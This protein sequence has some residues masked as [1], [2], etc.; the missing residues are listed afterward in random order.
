MKQTLPTL[1]LGFLFSIFTTNSY[2]QSPNGSAS[3]ALTLQCAS[4]T[5]NR[6]GIAYNPN[7]QYYYSINAGSGSYPIETFSSTGTPLASIS[8]GY[9]YRGFWWNPN[10]ST[11]E[12]KAYANGGIVRQNVDASFFPLGTGTTIV[13]GSAPDAQSCGDYDWVDDE[14]LYYYNG[15]AYRYDRST[16]TVISSV[17]I[18][19]LPVPIA[20]LNNNTAAYTNIPGMEFGVYD[21]VTKSFYFINKLTGAYVATCQLPATAPTA[22]SFQM[23]FENGYLWLYN[24]TTSQ[25]EGYGAVNVCSTSSSITE[26]ACASYTS[27]SGNTWT[28]SDVYTDTIPNAGGCDSVITIDLTVIPELTGMVQDTICSNGSVTVNGTTYDASTPTGT[29]VFTNVGPFGCDSTVTIDLTVLPE[30]ATLIEDT[31]CYNGSIVVNGTTYDAMN[32]SGS[33]TFTSS[34]AFGCDSS[35]L[36]DLTVLPAIDLNVTNVAATLTSDQAGATY[37]WI[38]CD[39]GNAAISGETNQSYSPTVTGNYAVVVTVNGC[40]D[41]SACVLVD[42][43]GIE[44]LTNSN[45]ELIMI[46][47]LTGRETEFRPNTPLIFIYSDGTRERVMDIKY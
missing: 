24:T 25:W 11:I 38:D 1:L 9:S 47:D 16:H 2:S 10:N 37:Q 18:T 43:T 45:K 15:S 32:P 8:S 19:G 12:G 39:N 35:V 3:L 34:G 31:I 5:S 28:V 42:F 17:A 20:N 44:E 13:T 27:P 26:S 4:G 14:V 46:I 22:A 33:E 7:Q 36:I 23:G 40:S 41:T 30:I 29:E 21:G 6:A